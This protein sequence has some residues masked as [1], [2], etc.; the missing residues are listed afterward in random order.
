MQERKT[1]NAKPKTQNVGMESHVEAS[2]HGQ[3]SPLNGRMLADR[4]RSEYVVSGCLISSGVREAVQLKPNK[5]AMI[6][7]QEADATVFT[8]RRA[9]PEEHP[10]E[11][12]EWALKDTENGNHR[13]EVTKKK[14]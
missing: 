9:D 2:Q 4:V 13:I 8:V 14:D 10:E 7:K 6:M 11:H 5:S 3:T 12:P 1:Q